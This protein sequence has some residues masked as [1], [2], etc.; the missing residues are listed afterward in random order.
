MPNGSFLV[1]I[2]G[3]AGEVLR[4]LAQ[5]AS[6]ETPLLLAS[7]MTESYLTF[8]CLLYLP[9]RVVIRIISINICK[10]HVC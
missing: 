4:F 1:S 10:L 9:P 3:T 7:Y 8:A 2:T 6:L 5:D